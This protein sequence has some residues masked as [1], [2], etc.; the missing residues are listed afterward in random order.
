MY[1]IKGW[2]PQMSEYKEIK[3]IVSYDGI[4]NKSLMMFKHSGLNV[5]NGNTHN[6]SDLMGL[7]KSNYLKLNDVVMPKYSNI[8]FEIYVDNQYQTKMRYEFFKT[9]LNLGKDHNISNLEIAVDYN[10]SST[11]DKS[12]KIEFGWYNLKRLRFE[13]I[14]NNRRYIN[15]KM[16][17]FHHRSISTVYSR[18]VYG[19][20]LKNTTIGD[21]AINKKGVSAVVS[22]DDGIVYRYFNK[23][24]SF[25]SKKINENRINY[26]I[27]QFDDSSYNGGGE[28][29]KI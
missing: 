3:N 22:T 19:Y 6:F 8:S 18:I 27:G 10:P 24:S 5:W 15:D 14:Y 11:L 28:R 23:I 1:D 12:K 4:D 17:C 2:D 7:T 29:V 26:K 20:Y 21:L 13:T 25:L 9:Y 16:L